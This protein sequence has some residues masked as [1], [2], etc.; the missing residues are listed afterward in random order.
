MPMPWD[1]Y[2]KRH[3]VDVVSFLKSRGC[4]NYK[5]FCEILLREDI[6]PPTQKSMEKYF[7]AAKPS[8]KPP[9]KKQT[10]GTKPAVKSAS[11]HQKLRQAKAKESSKKEIKDGD[12]S[13]QS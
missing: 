3:S 10:L 1:Y 7:A 8:R 12:G 4:E 11:R 6:E 13:E 5:S 9:P 2:V